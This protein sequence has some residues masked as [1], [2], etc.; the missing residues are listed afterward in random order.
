MFDKVKSILSSIAGP[1]RFFGGGLWRLIKRIFAPS[2]KGKL[3]WRIVGILLLT[4]VAAL[5]TYPRPYNDA[6][7]AVNNAAA[8]NSS[9]KWVKFPNVPEVSWKLGL[10]LL[11]GTHLVYEADMSG[12]GESERADA[13]AGVRDV[14]ERRVNTFGVSEPLV[15][16]E[17]AGSHYRIIVEL[18][19]IKDVNQAIKMIGETPTLDFREKTEGASTNATTL[20]V[21]E[22]TPEIKAYNADAKKR[23]EDV[24]KKVLAKG[25]DF[26]ALAKQY[27]ED[28]GSKEKGGDLGYF[29][30]GA[31]VKPFEDAVLKLKVGQVTAKLVETQFGYHIIKKTGVKT[32]EGKEQFSASHI[33]IGIKTAPAPE[34]AIAGW[35][36]TQLSGKQLKHAQVVFDPN[37]GEP[38]VQLTWNA[39]GDK[40]FGDITGANIGKQLGIFLDGQLISAPTVQSKITGGTAV[41]SGSFTLEETKTLAR[42]LNAGALPV[43][44]TLVTQQTV[45]ATLG[46]ASLE[47]SLFA[48][49]IGF[50]AVVVFMVSLYR[51]PGFMAALAL[52]VYTALTLGVF[53]FMNVTMTL[54]G[55]AGFILSIGMA[56][57]ANV[58][59]F[60]RVKEEL[61]NGRTVV[62]ALA[63][64]FKRAWNSIRDSN[65]SSLITCAILF[66]FGTSTVRGFALTLSIGILLS[67]FT[68]IIVTRNFLR[69]TIGSRVEKHLWLIGSKLKRNLKE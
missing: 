36:L 38:T 27:S 54:A 29:P 22:E 5:Y 43:P 31:M 23:A 18:A 45:D 41:I 2:N 6:A 33:L 52:C 63:E 65:I 42:R 12:I 25:A 30:K 40:L 44:I 24:L 47:K 64:G 57:D 55:I 37:S 49:L 20:T 67:M 8:Q 69:S 32:V 21:P 1:F 16:T 3:R 59:I 62:D 19:G 34:Q 46:T 68:A 4:I 39:E 14:I 51:L 61:R 26:A 50:L 58:L 60:E 13:L 9:T 15:Q 66:W 17:R 11:G 10:D 28:P 7:K 56:V 48:G 53:K 35:K